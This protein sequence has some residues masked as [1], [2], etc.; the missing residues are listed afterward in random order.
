M[1]IRDTGSIVEF[2]IKAGSSTYAYDMPWAYVVNDTSSD[3]QT[4]RFESGGSWQRVGSWNVS[5]DQTVSF[6]L[7]DTGTSGLGGPTTLSVAI[8]RGTVPA[9][10][11]TPVVSAIT[12]TTAFVTFTDGASP[13]LAI[14]A[15]QL[16]YGTSSTA[17]ATV[18]SSDRS[19]TIV[20]LSPGKTYYVWARTHNARGWSAWSGRRS[21]VTLRSPDPPTAPTITA[22][23]Q[24]TVVAMFKENFNGGSAV[25]EYQVG[26]GTDPVAPTASVS[27]VPPK[28]IGGLL[29]GVTYYFRARVKNG[30]GWS[31]WSSATPATTIAGVKVF[32]G[33]EWKNAV[34]YVKKDGVWKIARPWIRRS[35]IWRETS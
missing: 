6:K 5:V 7:G 25:I 26:Y 33:G 24:T 28:T 22:I 29:P 21:F 14:D 27:G 15:R 35:G 4:F 17:P 2:W 20:S 16:G 19:T 12:P 23:T 31:V 18:V 8:D 1:M 11:S 34:P 9:P 10:P 32:V 13:G 30:V 3:W